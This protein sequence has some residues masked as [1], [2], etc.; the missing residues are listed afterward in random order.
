MKVQEQD[1]NGYRRLDFEFEGRNAILVVPN[2]A[3]EGNPWLY[4]TEY[5]G[6]FP[7]FELAMLKRGWFLANLETKSRWV[8]EDD[9]EVKPRFCDFLQKEFGLA[10]QCLPVGMSCG[11][12]HAVYFAALYPRYVSALYLDAPVLNLLSCPAGVG[13]GNG[14]FF[15]EYCQITGKSIS[16][17][18]NYR[19]HAIDYTDA[20]LKANIPI[21]LVCGDA[22]ETVPYCENGEVLSKRYHEAGGIIEEVLKPGCGHHPHSLTDC[23]PIIRFAEQYGR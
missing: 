14:Q 8:I 9:N 2:Q 21:F 10:N 13:K 1:W 5:F 11:G 6:A 19:N 22:D 12:M 20:L 7:D 17:L 3:T 15:E 4:K 16:E 18:I 23:T